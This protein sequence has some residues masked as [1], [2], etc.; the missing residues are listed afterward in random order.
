MLHFLKSG[1]W[2]PQGGQMMCLSGQG[3]W[4]PVGMAEKEK[5]GRLSSPLS[6][7]YSFSEQTVRKCCMWPSRVGGV[8]SQLIMKQWPRPPH[9]ACHSALSRSL[10]L[11]L[12]D[13]VRHLPNKAL[14]PNSYLRLYFLKNQIWDITQEQSHTQSCVESSLNCHNILSVIWR[15]F[16]RVTLKQGPQISSIT[17]GVLR[18]AHSQ[19]VRAQTFLVFKVSGWFWSSLRIT[20]V[21]ILFFLFLLFRAAPVP[22]GSFQARGRIRATAARLHCRHSSSGSE[23][24]L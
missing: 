12:T 13:L 4:F 18:N 11:P 20:V 7:G 19:V 5:E 24:S 8:S 16:S 17:W 3:S 21:E 6:H 14:T 15:Y 1:M 2:F 22:H 9:M 10:F 23:P